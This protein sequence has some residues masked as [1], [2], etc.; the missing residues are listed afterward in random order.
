MTSF[1]ALFLD[2]PDS[3]MSFPSIVEDIWMRQG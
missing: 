3:T 2:L 1:I